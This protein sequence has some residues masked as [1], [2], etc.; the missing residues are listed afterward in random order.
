MRRLRIA[1]VGTRG[2]PATYGGV[3]RH[4]EEIGS[5]IAER[6]HEVTVYAR[7]GYLEEPL[8][9][10]RG[11][12]IRTLRTVDSKHLEAFLHSAHAAMDALTRAN[13]VVHFHALGPGLFS[14]INRYA[15]RAVVVQTIHGRD[16]Q[17][18]KWGG[19]AQRALR[20]ATW[21]STQVPHRTIV[22]SREL[23]TDY[24]ESFG[25]PSTYI[26]NGTPD[27]IERPPKEISRIWGLQGGDYVLALGRL[28][29]EKDAAT[30]IRAFRRVQTDAKLVIVGGSSHSGD[31]VASL[32]ALAA[33]DPRVIMTGYQYGDV[34][35]ELLSNARLFAQ[36]SLLEGLPLT[37][38]E[39]ASYGLPIVAS[40]IGPHA[41][42]LADVPTGAKMFAV[43]IED[44]L[45]RTLRLMLDQHT[46]AKV[47]SLSAHVRTNYSWDRAADQVLDTYR[48]ALLQRAGRS[49]RSARQ[50]DRALDARDGRS[51]VLPPSQRPTPVVDLAPLPRQRIAR[52]GT[53]SPAPASRSS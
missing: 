25:R 4:V 14:P 9:E 42:V 36:P 43:G 26:P 7:A 13:D 30:L 28:V 34:L 32:Q 53:D 38:L 51:T 21:V 40:D 35:E 39:A 46:G 5:R 44:D 6:G 29:P 8:R 50:T 19:T 27:P 16:D 24:Q 15:S 33:E 3:E 22:V 18:N 48:D 49:R 37:L 12:Q 23:Q 45:V 20:V 31:Y 47:P 11:M 17:R 41:E 1:I 2:I 10:H 52:A